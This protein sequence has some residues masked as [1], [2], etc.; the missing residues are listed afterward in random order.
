MPRPRRSFT[1]QKR[2]LNTRA[3][4]ISAL[5]VVV[6]AAI[7]V[8]SFFSCRV[9]EGTIKLDALALVTSVKETKQLGELIRL[10]SPVYQQEAIRTSDHLGLTADVLLSNSKFPVT[11]RDAIPP[12]PD[13]LELKTRGRFALVSF[14]DDS[15]KVYSFKL[16][17]DGGKWYFYLE[18]PLEISK[19][20]DF[21]VE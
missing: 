2:P 8:L 20:G 1:R 10:A 19:Y 9:K 4:A 6:I 17:Q 11:L 7:A 14:V 16:V 3:I 21:R 18:T 5:V 15:K 12:Q 13:E